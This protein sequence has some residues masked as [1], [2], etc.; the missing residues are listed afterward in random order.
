M[1]TNCSILC[2]IVSMVYPHILFNTAVYV[3][4]QVHIQS[5]R[6]PK[7]YAW[8]EY[9]VLRSTMTL[10][11][12]RILLWFCL[13][14]SFYSC[15][16]SCLYWFCR[17]K[18]VVTN[19]ENMGNIL[20]E[21][22]KNCFIHKTQHENPVLICGLH[23]ISWWRHQTGTFSAL[24]A[25][26]AGNSPV[27]GELPAQR[28]VTRIFDVFSNL[29]LNKRLSN[30]GDLRRHRSQYDVIVMYYIYDICITY[31]SPFHYYSS[32]YIVCR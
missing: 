19:L 6:Q 32:A 20:Y 4:T 11:T 9:P 25:I 13:Y 27:T 8:K 1:N 7:G 24:M 26:C 29:L 18:S 5:L 16:A 30:A 2:T 21:S 17:N 14:Q 3:N 12:T 31:I 28:P 22:A 23:S 10:S 15:P